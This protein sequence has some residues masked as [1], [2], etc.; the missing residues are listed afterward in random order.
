MEPEELRATLAEF[1]EKHDD[2]I[3]EYESLQE[4][5]EG[6]QS[7]YSEAQDALDNLRTKFAEEAADYINLSP[8]IIADRFSYSEI[9]Q[10]IEEGEKAEEFAEDEDE[11]VDAFTTFSEKEEKGREEGGNAETRTDAEQR[12]GSF[13]FPSGN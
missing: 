4:D 2:N 13:G 5:H 11:E 1:M 8:E 6:L 7:E 3:E 9:T 10:I 12:L